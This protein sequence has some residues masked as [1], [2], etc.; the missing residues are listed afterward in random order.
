MV[1]PTDW[2]SNMSR[3][4]QLTEH[5]S[6][7]YRFLHSKG[8]GLVF[9]LSG[10]QCDEWLQTGARVYSAPTKEENVA[11]SCTAST[12]IGGRVVCITESMKSQLLASKGNASV[13]SALEV[14]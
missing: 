10:G 7:D 5:L 14:P 4:P 13:C 2:C 12:G 9:C 6:Q 3:V 11:T 1:V 8:E